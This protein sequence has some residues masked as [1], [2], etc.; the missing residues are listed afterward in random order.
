MK[1]NL[2]NIALLVAYLLI[3]PILLAMIYNKWHE[4]KVTTDSQKI[5]EQY[6]HPFTPAVEEKIA[7]LRDNINN[8]RRFQSALSQNADNNYVWI[9]VSSKITD[10]L[11][12]DFN[13]QLTVCKKNDNL[14]IDNS[15]LTDCYGFFAKKIH[16]FGRKTDTKNL[17]LLTQQLDHPNFLL[18]L[19]N[20]SLFVF[21]EIAKKN[22]DVPNAFFD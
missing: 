2:R 6:L 12:K 1:T 17:Y 22:F 3:L 14:L 18:S 21:I 10:S 16:N 9:I 20:D 11:S 13:F 7:Q 4:T 15:I 19:G 8:D 5:L